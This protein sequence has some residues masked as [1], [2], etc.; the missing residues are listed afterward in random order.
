MTSTGPV[1]LIT[2]ADK[3]LGASTARTALENGNRVIATVLDKAGHHP[4]ANEYPD[5]FRAFHLDM[6]DIDRIPKVARQ[7]ES[8]FGRVDI[9]VN[10]AGYGLL[11]IAEAT[12]AKLYRELFEVLFF[13]LA[14]ITRAILP[15]MRGRKSGHIINLSSV[16]GFGVGP[17]FAFYGA[18]KFAVEGY[19]EALHAELRDMGIRVT[20][21][22]PGGFRSDFAGASLASAKVD[23]EDYDAVSSYIDSYTKDRHGTQLNDPAR[24]GPAIYELVNSPEAPL[25]LALG[26]DALEF[27]R[28]QMAQVAGDL[29]KWESLSRSTSIPAS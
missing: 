2:G 9:L 27:I 25:R 29:E 1:W 21:V 20:I 23:I 4:L 5:H 15:G 22:E 14:E 3:G 26:E 18:A 6:R 17:G 16:A 10:N 24:F 7:A 19:S 8:A 11:A 13:S 12:P 28:G